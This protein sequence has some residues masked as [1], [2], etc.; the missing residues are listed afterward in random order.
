MKL[1]D[2]TTGAWQGAYQI[3]FIGERRDD[4]VIDWSDLAGNEDPRSDLINHPSH[5]LKQQIKYSVKIRESYVSKKDG[6][7]TY[8]V[9]RQ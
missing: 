6:R 3:R 2:P 7:H 4:P 9:S 5:P 8:A 1:K